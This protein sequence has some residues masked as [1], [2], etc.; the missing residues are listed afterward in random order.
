MW[1]SWFGL[2]TEDYGG[3]FGFGLG[4]LLDLELELVVADLAETPLDLFVCHFGTFFNK[5]KYYNEEENICGGVWSG[6]KERS[7]REIYV[8]CCWFVY[9]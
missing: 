9:G 8:I 1:I 3:R 4:V 7:V 6:R 2:V 5:G